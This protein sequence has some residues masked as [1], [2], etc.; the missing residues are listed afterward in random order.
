VKEPSH[1]PLCEIEKP[2]H[3]RNQTCRHPIAQELIELDWCCGYW[4][5]QSAERWCPRGGLGD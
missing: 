5:P 2:T 1:L 3:R 4:R